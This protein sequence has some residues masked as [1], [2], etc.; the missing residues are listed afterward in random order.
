MFWNG[1]S[2]YGAG[3]AHSVTGSDKPPAMSLATW[4]MPVT[5]WH[6]SATIYGNG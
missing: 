6:W 2:G 4:C 5:V 1:N 3:T